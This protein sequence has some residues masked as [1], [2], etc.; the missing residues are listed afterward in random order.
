MIS[1]NTTILISILLILVNVIPIYIYSYRKKKYGLYPLM[2]FMVISCSY[3]LYYSIPFKKSIDDKEHLHELERNADENNNSEIH[4]AGDI[5]KEEKKIATHLN[6]LDL[7]VRVASIQ[8]LLCIFLCILGLILVYGR[9]KYYITLLFVHCI[10]FCFCCI[11][12][13]TEHFTN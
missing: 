13:I 9:N 12:E 3:L 5:A 6:N 2:I 7:I 11:L 4:F 10:L 8:S 1:T